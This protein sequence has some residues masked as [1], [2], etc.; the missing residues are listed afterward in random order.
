MRLLMI[1][2]TTYLFTQQIHTPHQSGVTSTVV[3]LSS[4]YSDCWQYAHCKCLYISSSSSSSSWKFIRHPLRGSAAT[5]N[6]V[7]ID[8]TKT[9]Q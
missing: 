8:Y 1:Y 2:P 9:Q 6:T 4:V 7:S 3:D 5:W